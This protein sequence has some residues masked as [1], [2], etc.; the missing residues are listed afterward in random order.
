MEAFD[1]SHDCSVLLLKFSLGSAFGAARHKTDGRGIAKDLYESLRGRLAETE[2]AQ[3]EA[4][5]KAYSK[6]TD[7][8]HKQQAE[9]T[10]L[11]TVPAA[12]G[13]VARR[14]VAPRLRR[15]QCAKRCWSRRMRCTTSTRRGEDSSA[16]GA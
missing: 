6:L 13:G 11:L 9:T 14:F 7:L 5:R 16:A 8:G 2:M 4:A 10:K 3:A 12:K 15:G 1:F